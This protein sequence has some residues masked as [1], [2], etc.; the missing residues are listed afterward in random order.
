MNLEMEGLNDNGDMVEIVLQ[1]DDDSNGQDENDDNAGNETL[2]GL[3]CYE[4]TG[5]GGGEVKHVSGGA[6]LDGVQWTVALTCVGVPGLLRCNAGWP[7]LS[8][9]TVASENRRTSVL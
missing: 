8:V 3:H 4:D 2:T 5:A 7:R 1:W 9:V 6:G